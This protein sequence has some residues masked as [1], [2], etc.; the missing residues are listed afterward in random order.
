M[1]KIAIISDVH[2]NMP[3]LET[4][5]EDIRRRGIDLIYNLGDLVGKGPNSDLA[6][7]RCREVCQVIVRGNWDDTIATAELNPAG[8]WYHAQIGLERIMYLA[9]L[10]NAYDFWLSGKR[11]RLY[12][13]S[14]ESVFKRIHP[15]HPYEDLRRMFGNTPFTGLDGRPPDI[16]GYGDIHS[17]YMLSLSRDQKVLFNAG[18]VGNPLDRPLATYVILSGELDS[19]EPGLFSIDFV[20][21]PYDIEQ[22]IEEA[23]RLNTPD[24]EAYAVELRTA[25][26]RGR[27]KAT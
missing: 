1:D 10:P 5:L 20:R 26:Y 27:Q 18:S 8:R 24:V 13:A 3:A 7:D 25:V 4:V 6:I 2:G 12:H 15:S 21:L 11:V 9:S 16:V 22:A 19:Q 14:E 23:R 17:A